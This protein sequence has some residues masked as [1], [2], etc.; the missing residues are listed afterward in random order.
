MVYE[1][2]GSMCIKQRLSGNSS[3]AS[4]KGYRRRDLV[5]HG[6]RRRVTA[7]S[8]PIWIDAFMD[9]WI[10]VWAD[11]WMHRYYMNDTL[12]MGQINE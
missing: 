9:E 5:L 12:M 7:I 8:P 3:V 1:D 2:T 10:F 4:I 11:G 6:P